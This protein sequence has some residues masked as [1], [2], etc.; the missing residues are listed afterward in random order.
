LSVQLG[1][2]TLF[3]SI[4]NLTTV[5]LKQNIIKRGKNKVIFVV[6]WP[7]GV[8]P[9][10]TWLLSPDPDARVCVGVRVEPGCGH[11]ARVRFR[12]KRVSVCIKPWVAR[13]YC[14]FLLCLR[15]YM[16]G[17]SGLERV[18]EHGLVVCLRRQWRPRAQRGHLR[19]FNERKTRVD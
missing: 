2:S 8:C 7:V 10:L 17:Q 15:M 13:A 12:F 19:W 11:E 9:S 18:G 3:Y 6:V 4:P 1:F 5:V 16:T 14:N